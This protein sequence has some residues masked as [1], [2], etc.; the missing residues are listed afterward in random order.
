MRPGFYRLFDLRNESAGLN[1]LNRAGPYLAAAF[2][3]P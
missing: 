2:K 1:V 3:N